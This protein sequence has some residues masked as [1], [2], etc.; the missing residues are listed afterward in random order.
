[1]SQEERA[2][3]VARAIEHALRE[4]AAS[5]LASISGE[6]SQAFTIA[7]RGGCTSCNPGTCPQCGHLFT[8]E[9]IEI[10]HASRGKRV[11]SDKA[12][13]YLSHGMNC[14][15]TGWIVH[16]EPVIVDLDVDEVAGY[17]DL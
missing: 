17:L 13:H 10:V 15:E 11:L 9:V 5:E 6:S 1:M 14:Y 2:R 7:R 3:Q 16:G 12:V 8:G 4:P